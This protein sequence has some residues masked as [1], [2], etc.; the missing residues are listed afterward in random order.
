[1]TKQAAASSVTALAQARPAEASA[2]AHAVVLAEC[3]AHAAFEAKWRRDG[4]LRPGWTRRSTDGAVLTQRE[5]SGFDPNDRFWIVRTDKSM[6]ASHSDIEEPVF[7]DFVRQLYDAL[8]LD[9]NSC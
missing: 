5:N 2:A 3:K 7:V 9:G 1:M 4:Y 6:I 8:L